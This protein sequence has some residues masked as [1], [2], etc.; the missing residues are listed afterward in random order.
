MQTITKKWHIFLSD[1]NQNR[2]ISIVPNF[3][4]HETLI[5]EDGAALRQ[6]ELDMTKPTVAFFHPSTTANKNQ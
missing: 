6:A 1:F 3:K 4:F 2:H 5:G